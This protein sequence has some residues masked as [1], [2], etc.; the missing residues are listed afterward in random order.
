VKHS[1]WRD[2]GSV[3]QR[4]QE[5]WGSPV[6]R[7]AEAHC[8]KNL[9]DLSNTLFRARRCRG[10][11]RGEAPRAAFRERADGN[12]ERRS[13]GGNFYQRNNRPR[14]RGWPGAREIGCTVSRSCQGKLGRQLTCRGRQNSWLPTALSPV[15]AVSRAT[16]PQTHVAKNQ[17][18][19][20][21][22]AEVCDE[23]RA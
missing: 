23:S 17:C 19:H 14:P 5:Q 4:R 22:L 18:V 10:R 3:Q 12:K 9:C 13:I 16:L 8:G 15:R 2:L 11:V 1:P 6:I 7:F 21:R 20:H